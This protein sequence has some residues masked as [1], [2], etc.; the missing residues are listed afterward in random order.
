LSWQ[1]VEVV[2]EILELVVEQV[3]FGAQYLPRAV[4]VQLG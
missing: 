2:Q 3:D 4:V 1:V